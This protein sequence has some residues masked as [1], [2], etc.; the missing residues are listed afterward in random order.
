[1]KPFF[2]LGEDIPKPVMVINLRNEATGRKG[3]L[4]GDRHD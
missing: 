3:L 4:T 2:G 1:M